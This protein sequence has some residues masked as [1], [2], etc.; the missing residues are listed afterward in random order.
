MLQHYFPDYD[1]GYATGIAM[2]KAL[3]LTKIVLSPI[4]LPMI[5]FVGIVLLVF[6]AVVGSSAVVGSALQGKRRQQHYHPDVFAKR[7]SSSTAK[8]ASDVLSSDQCIERISCE[9]FKKARKLGADDDLILRFVH[10]FI[11]KSLKYT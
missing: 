6:F 1:T 3:G 7:L 2:K 9:V 8:L 5:F 4:V 10:P 11:C